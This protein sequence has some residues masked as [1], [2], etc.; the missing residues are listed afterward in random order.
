M[1]GIAH[2]IRWPT[3]LQIADWPAIFDVPIISPS[4]V[5]TL[6]PFSSSDI[7]IRGVFNAFAAHTAK[8]GDKRDIDLKTK[9]LAPIEKSCSYF[10]A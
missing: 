3:T 7:L 6:M 1:A 10:G 4:L 5:V 2:M 9:T 8:N